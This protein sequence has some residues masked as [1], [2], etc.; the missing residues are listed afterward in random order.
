MRCECEEEEEEEEEKGRGRDKK[1][2]GVHGV[3]RG[4]QV[5]VRCDKM[6]GG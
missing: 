5:M 2:K 1:K 6:E 4:T 3:R